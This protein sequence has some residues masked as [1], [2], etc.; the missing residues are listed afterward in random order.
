MNATTMTAKNAV[1]K[2]TD[3]TNFSFK[4]ETIIVL[5]GDVPADCSESVMVYSPPFGLKK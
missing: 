4:R 2:K 3:L 1:R 5:H